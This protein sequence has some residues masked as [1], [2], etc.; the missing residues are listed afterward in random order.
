M[1]LEMTPAPPKSKFRRFI[2]WLGLIIGPVAVFVAGFGLAESRPL[3]SPQSL[4]GTLLYVLVHVFAVACIVALLVWLVRWV[5][6]HLKWFGRLAAVLFTWRNARRLL[7]GLVI[8]ATLIAVFYAEENWRGKRAWE[9]CKRDLEAKGEV[10]D[11]SAYIPAPVPDDQNVFKAPKI[12]EWFVK[13]RSGTF[14][15]N[16]LS[17]KFNYWPLHDATE[18]S[19]PKRPVLV[20]Q[21][22]I[23]PP[24]SHVGGEGERVRSDAPDAKERLGRIVQQVVGP[25]ADGPQGL[26]FVLRQPNQIKPVRLWLETDERLSFGDV[27]R[28]FPTNLVSRK[29]GD[30]RIEAEATPGSFRIVLA[31][32]P[33]ISAE[34]YLA[35]TDAATPE[36]NLIREA[37]KRPQ[38]RMDGDFQ[39]PLERPIVNFVVMRT[40]AQTLASRA[41]CCFLLGRP[42]QAIREL[43]LISESRRLLAAKP[44]TLVAA[45]IDVAICGLYVGTA[46]DGFRLQAWREPDLVAIQQQLQVINL[47]PEVA[48]SI[49]EDR[50]ATCHNLQIMTAD[51]LAGRLIISGGKANLWEKLNDPVYQLVKFAP[52][53]WF[54]QNLVTSAKLVQATIIGSLNL[55]TQLIDPSKTMR[56]NKELEKNLAR[57]WGSPFKVLAG[58][59]IPNT[60]RA[61]TTAARNQTLAN[62]ALVVCGLERCRR[63]HGEYP[64]TLDALVPQ[65]VEKLPRDII[66]GQPLH[67]RRTADGKFLLYSVGWNETDDGG[68]PGKT[69]FDE[70]E[71]D[72]V[73]EIPEK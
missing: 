63:M 18:Q 53:G 26:T 15:T 62:Q 65:F 60:S 55:D 73:W 52:R 4:A 19:D 2:R 54:Y 51:N 68:T 12:A 70:K 46:T 3:K 69:W 39:R 10:L 21:V 41:Q 7:A 38:I 16:E 1:F 8:L 22:K 67:Y 31:T 24:N 66:G 25:S 59:A 48:G 58:I 29:V 40:F 11:W 61:L 35:V 20:A 33:V 6:R 72:W 28:L 36:F 43:S 42:E 57:R 71:G 32:E 56:A 27:L 23:V 34:D 37:L 49:R 44:T 17:A 14:Y 47:P 50:A 9:K 64:E 5:L 13:P 30:L 45:M